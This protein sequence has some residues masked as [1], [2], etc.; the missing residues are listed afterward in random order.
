MYAKTMTIL[1]RTAVSL[2][3]L[4]GAMPFL[5]IAASAAILYAPRSES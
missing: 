1:D 3:V 5:S 2:M 4:L